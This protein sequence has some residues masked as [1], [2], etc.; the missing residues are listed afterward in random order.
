MDQ[1]MLRWAECMSSH[2]FA[3]PNMGA[4]RQ[5]VAAQA[6]VLPSSA[7]NRQ[8]KVATTDADCVVAVGIPQLADQLGRRFTDTLPDAQR[9]ELNQ[10]AELRTAALLRAAVFVK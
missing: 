2:G 4:A 8:I 7:L 10:A 5:A 1:A 3:Y 9:G 6:V